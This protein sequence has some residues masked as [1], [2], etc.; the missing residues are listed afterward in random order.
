MKKLIVFIF[1]AFLISSCGHHRK[2]T[3]KSNKVCCAKKSKCSGK[4][5][6]LK[7]K[8][9]KCSGKSC[10]LKHKKSKCSTKSCKHSSKKKASN[11]PGY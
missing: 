5:C 7:K 8:S 2:C 4:S 1:M 3:G 10:S 11:G 9:K 6:S